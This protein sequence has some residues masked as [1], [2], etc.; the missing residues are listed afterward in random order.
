M[1]ELALLSVTLTFIALG[2]LSPFV[3]SLGYVWVDTLLP[4]RLSYSILASLP[5]A[6]IMGASAVGFYLVA[7][8]R[9]P[10]RISLLHV[11]ILVLAVWIT[12]TSSWAILPDAA[13]SKWNTSFKTLLFVMFMPFVF[14][15]RVQVEAFVLVFLF[16]AAGHLLPWG[17]KTLLSGGGYELS[18]GLMDVNTTMLAESSA[19]SAVTIMFIPILVWMRNHSLLI[20]WPRIR[21]WGAAG[22]IVVFLI[23]NI[24]T[25]ART[26]LVALAVLGCGMFLKT[27]RK[28][29]FI[30]I[31]LI[32]AGVAFN[33]MSDRWSARISTINDYQT[34]SSALVR[35]LVWKWTLEFATTHPFGG[36]FNAY[37]TNVL[38]V[39]VGPDGETLYQRGRAYHNIYMAALGEHG[40]PGL[41][42]YLTILVVSL[43][44]MQR[45]IRLA[46]GRPDLVWAADLCRAT[47]IALLVQMACGN[48]VDISF[49]IL[50][51]DVIAIALCLNCHVQQVVNPRLTY[52]ERMAQERAPPQ[53][54]G[55]PATAPAAAVA[56]GPP[57][58]PANTAARQ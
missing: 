46:K 53:R 31:A 37:F 5:L 38:N 21:T 11:L 27:K 4:H 45:S 17:L 24:G 56:T 14:R 57:R 54:P 13:W 42:L 18:L 7:D 41:A 48:F 33:F 34:E 3:L 10:P 2:V 16:S 30:F 12:L 23:G 55:A 35:L 25:F 43:V 49:N 22:M 20:P 29:L 52:A 28:G 39:G 32:M 50:V 47:Q 8:R 51:W 6:F 36:G 19:V 58:I 44:S 9:S 1:Q 15:T 40:Y 26:G